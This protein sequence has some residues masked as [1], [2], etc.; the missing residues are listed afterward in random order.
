FTYDYDISQKFNTRFRL[1]ADQLAN[2]SNGKIGVFV[3]E[4][5]LKWKDIFG[6]STFGF[7][8]QPTPAF[9]I[10]E[11]AWG[12]R[13][14]EKTIMDLRGIVTREDIALSLRGRLDGDGNINYWVMFGD[15]SGNTPETDKYKRYYGMLHA[16]PFKNFQVTAYG[17]LG[18]RAH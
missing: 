10:S 1:E 18:A 13:S 7:G 12:Y 9:D 4:A 16:K 17:D 8:I 2:T 11:A 6:G 3:K 15:N 14:L 5:Y